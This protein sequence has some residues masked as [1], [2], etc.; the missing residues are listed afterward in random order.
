M[1]ILCADAKGWRGKLFPLYERSAK[2]WGKN[3]ANRRAA[4]T[5]NDMVMNSNEEGFYG[6]EFDLGMGFSPLSPN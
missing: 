2:I 5:P 6:K 4:K 3:R 1:G